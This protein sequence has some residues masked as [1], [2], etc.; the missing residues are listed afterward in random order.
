MY[1]R[2]MTAMD[3]RA[4]N[5]AVSRR[6]VSG[7]PDAAAMR[8][9]RPALWFLWF[10][11]ARAEEM[12]RARWHQRA[13]DRLR[14]GAKGQDVAIESDCGLAAGAILSRVRPRAAR[15]QAYVTLP[16]ELPC[17]RCN[18]IARVRC[19]IRMYDCSV[20]GTAD[21][22]DGSR[23]VGR[24]GSW[25]GLGTI[26]LDCGRAIFRGQDSAAAGENLFSLS[27][28]A[29]QQAARQLAAG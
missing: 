26:P 12:R 21:A 9:L 13:G 4:I 19:T 23:G 6:A 14:V 5:R 20:W 15:R 1:E 28:A 22:L 25:L 7:G 16:W 8:A 18:H 17:H 2:D 11:G 24:D 3:F 10:T 29:G 27:L